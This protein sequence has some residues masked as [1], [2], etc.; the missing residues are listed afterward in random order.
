MLAN[1]K[2]TRKEISII[3]EKV[4]IHSSIKIEFV[5]K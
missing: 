1:F 2:K 3:G 4:D 5:A